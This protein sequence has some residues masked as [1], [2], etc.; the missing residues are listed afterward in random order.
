MT[1]NQN[2]KQDPL[3]PKF[4]LNTQ[5]GVRGFLEWLFDPEVDKAI[6]QFIKDTSEPEQE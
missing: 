1:E 2:P 6:E 4:D 5:A 3:N